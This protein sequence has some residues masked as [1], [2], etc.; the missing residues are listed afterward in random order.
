MDIRSLPRYRGRRDTGRGRAEPDG[1]GRRRAVRLR[2]WV[3]LALVA[4]FILPLVP[5]FAARAASRAG[6][7]GFGPLVGVAAA[8]A[9][10]RLGFAAAVADSPSRACLISC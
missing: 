1:H 7:G 10:D 9:F 2:D 3:F 6:F 8:F 4:A 5:C